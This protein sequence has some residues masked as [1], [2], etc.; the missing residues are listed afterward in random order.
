MAKKLFKILALDGGGIRGILPATILKAIEEKTGKPTAELFD[1]VAGTSTGGIIAAGLLVPHEQNPAQPKYSAETLLNLYVKEGARIFKKRKGVR[2]AGSNITDPTYEH[3]GLEGVLSEYFSDNTLKEVL[4]PLVVTSYDL[5]KRMPF[6]FRSRLA[7]N[8]TLE[9]DFLLRH[10]TRATS[11]APTYFE[12]ALIH[13]GKGERLVLVDGGVCAN[14]PSIVAYGEAEELDRINRTQ[15]T[16]AQRLRD[17]REHGVKKVITE[18]DI[19]KSS[20]YFMLS[21][22]TGNGLRPYAYEKTKEW[23]ALKWT[24]PAI[25]ILMQGSAEV[26]HNHMQYIMPESP[27]GRH[28]IRFNTLVDKIYSDMANAKPEIIHG[29]QAIADRFVMDNEDRIEYVCRKLVE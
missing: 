27:L 15:S 13:N 6:Y 11:A 4:K 5:E 22:G 17:S 19:A 3:Q 16:T 14:N 12:P 8:Q 28:Y 29:L 2:V 7:Q 26:N 18:P 25:D 9:E 24:I 21:I 1:L 23:G 10:V 20:D